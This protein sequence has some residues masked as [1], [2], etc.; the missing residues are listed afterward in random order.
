[1]LF[2][3]PVATLT[4]L[5]YQ[6]ISEAP[7]AARYGAEMPVPD[8]HARLVCGGCGSRRS[9]WSSPGP[10]GGHRKARPS[11]TGPLFLGADAAARR[12]SHRR[13]LPPLTPRARSLRPPA[14]RDPAGVSTRSIAQAKARPSPAAPLSS[15][16]RRSGLR[17]HPRRQ[18][19]HMQPVMH[20]DLSDDET[21]ALIRERHDIAERDRSGASL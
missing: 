9:T 10:S 1:M 5:A 3:A 6:R 21:A 17:L 20:L 2:D 7:K 15:P 8:W 11:P 19:H 14:P 18:R 13:A 16:A 4:S 12:S